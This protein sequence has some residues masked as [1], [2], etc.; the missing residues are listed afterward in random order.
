MTRITRET[1]ETS[2]TVALARSG[3][4][5]PDGIRTSDAFLDHML[6]TLARYAGWQLDLAA[7]GDLR[8]HLIEDVAITLGLAVA[9]EMPE[10]CTRYGDALVPMD[11]ALV[12]V[13]IDCG[14][15]PWYQGPLPVRLYDHFLRSFADHARIT[16]HLHVMR[17]RDRHHT[18]EAAFKALGLAL[19]EALSESAAVFSTKG[20]VRIRRDS[21]S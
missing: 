4:T 3:E 16:V 21:A 2:V 6:A 18:V 10:A 7:R 5:A 8:H 12:Q 20:S 17:G 9:D 11:D 19:R 14:G 15:R 13:A 1:R